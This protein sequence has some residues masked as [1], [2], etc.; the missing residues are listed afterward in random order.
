MQIIYANHTRRVPVMHAEGI[1]FLDIMA[2][3]LNFKCYCSTITAQPEKM[4]LN[5]RNNQDYSITPKEKISVIKKQTC[6]NHKKWHVITS[7][8]LHGR[9]YEANKFDLKCVIFFFIT[10]C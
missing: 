9:M 3:F 5:K 10:Y 2:I 4:G 1:P 7:L 6:S 8:L